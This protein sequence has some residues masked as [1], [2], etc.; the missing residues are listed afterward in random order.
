M[1]LHVEMQLDS[2]DTKKRGATIAQWFNVS[3]NSLLL[4]TAPPGA[5]WTAG[6]AME[7]GDSLE[8]FEDLDSIRSDFLG[9]LVCFPYAARL[10][11]MCG[12]QEIGSV[13]STHAVTG[14]EHSRLTASLQYGSA[15]LSDPQRC[16]RLVDAVAQA[17][18]Q[19][20]PA[21]GR[22]ECDQFSEYSNLD[23]ALRRKP[24]EYLPM[25]RHLLRG[26]A[27]TTICPE[28]L[29]GRLGGVDALRKTGAFARVVRLER[30]VVLQSTDTV[31]GFSAEAMN[32]VFE[33]LAPVLPPGMP[34]RHPAFPDIRYIPR[35][36]SAV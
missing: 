16:N 25:S 5:S 31:A 24:D 12:E 33:A 26:Y 28:E 8:F 22:I 29:V 4:Q 14:G 13:S 23:L 19:A 30:G 35:D 18:N 17:L 10:V 2:R 21:F 3:L 36:A 1:D 20:D 11:L 7:E 34:K 6:L 9:K 32:A 27:W 15:A